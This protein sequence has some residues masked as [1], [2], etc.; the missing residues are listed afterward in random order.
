MNATRRNL[1]WEGDEISLKGK[2]GY[3]NLISIGKR[4]KIF[5]NAL[6]DDEGLSSFQ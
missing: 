6:D 5:I 2:M 3:A 4:E 1:I